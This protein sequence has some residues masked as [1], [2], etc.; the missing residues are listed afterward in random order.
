[1]DLGDD[2]SSHSF[3][4][5]GETSVGAYACDD[6]NNNNLGGD[7]ATLRLGNCGSGTGEA[8]WTMD[9]GQYITFSVAWQ[10][11]AADV[12]I[13]GS[14]LGTIS[15]APSGSGTSCTDHTFELP[16][17]IGSTFEVRVVDPT[18]GCTGDI[19]IASVCVSGDSYVYTYRYSYFV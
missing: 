13:D 14:Y 2:W 1:M 7:D 3:S 15:G 12:Y 5:S 19:Q 8:T 9:A 4:S 17:T 11:S 18:T 6:E 10:N 16:S